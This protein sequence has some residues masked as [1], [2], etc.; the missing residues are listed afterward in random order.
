MIKKILA[1]VLVITIFLLCYF[2][3]ITNATRNLKL[4]TIKAVQ[5]KIA[6][7]QA[8]EN[9]YIQYEKFRESKKIGEIKT[10]L[11]DS[12]IKVKEL[13]SQ[14]IPDNYQD[15]VY[16]K[17]AT[18]F[19]AQFLD[20]QV[21][22][23]NKIINLKNNLGSI[24][25]QQKVLADYDSKKYDDLKTLEEFDSKTAQELI[26]QSSAQVSKLL[27][28]S[29]CEV[30]NIAENIEKTQEIASDYISKNGIQI[31]PKQL[32]EVVKNYISKLSLE[33]NTA[34]VFAK[35]QSQKLLQDKKL[36][37]ITENLENYK[38]QQ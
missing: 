1:F 32:Q 23:K 5:T 31:S 14:E 2:W 34:Q 26:V 29:Q 11:D 22:H 6:Q 37:T 8:W 9:K 19:Q 38:N 16:G 4:E 3:Y 27:E 7:I 30:N 35:I 10:F 17:K 12:K 20:F 13:I 33:E 28:L 24:E 18:E 25:C 21:A 36:Q 15:L